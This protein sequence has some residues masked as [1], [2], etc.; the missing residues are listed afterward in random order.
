MSE[1]LF[2]LGGGDEEVVAECPG[3]RTRINALG[4]TV[5]MTA[6]LAVVAGTSATHDWLHASLL[7]ALPAGI[8]WG[9]AIMNL[10]RWLLLTIRRQ[11]TPLRTL[12]LALPRLG[13]ALVVGLV[14]STPTLLGVF[15]SEV[16]A[17]ATEERQA[18]EA[19]AKQELSAQF[20]EIEA[21]SEEQKGLQ[22]KLSANLASSVLSESPDYVEL[23]KQLEQEQKRSDAAQ[24]DALC[25]L[26]GTCGTGHVGAGPS[27]EAKA[28]EAEKLAAELAATKR[29]LQS[30]KLKLL[31]EARSNEQQAKG[32]AN[33][34]LATVNRELT[35]MRGDYREK[36]QDLEEAYG[37]EVG[38]LDRIDA[39]AALTSEH[40][41]M[42]YVAIL[43]ALFILAIDS[44][45][46]LFK[47]LT[48]LARP[49]QYEWFQEDRDERGMNRHAIEQD[50]RDEVRRIEIASDLQ[51]VR[52][53]AKMQGE[54]MADR[55][56]RIAGLERE[57]TDQLVPEMRA[58]M[59][60]MV[61]ELAERYLARQRMTWH[62]GGGG[63]PN[64]GPGPQD[65]SM[66]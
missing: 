33:T 46:V 50:S 20:G 63:K 11:S 61:P 3:E 42:L 14:I 31:H 6:M 48:L 21:L 51:E 32:F 62:P 55:Q 29:Q 58:R 13:L 45:P 57:L 22:E 30:L 59:L 35:E 2:W 37:A 64:G 7:L 10:D 27:Y 53:H 18:E 66:Q 1:F 24:G 49:T 43:L 54:A 16:T 40:P 17:K 41:S 60:E 38:L 23:Q 28:Q 39:L 25:E 9:L 15:D 34:E 8:F 5:L 56:R 44:V 47:T 4:G 12:L 36:K 26:D 52:M 19:E 65:P